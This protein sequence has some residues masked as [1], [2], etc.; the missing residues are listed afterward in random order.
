MRAAGIDPADLAEVAGH[1]VEVATA[2]YTHSLGR[3][4]EQIRGVVG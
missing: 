4:D 1:T 2:R 3:S